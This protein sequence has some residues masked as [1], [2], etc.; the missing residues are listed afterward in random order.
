MDVARKNG[1]HVALTEFTRAL[2]GARLPSHASSVSQ[3]A[4]AGA[5]S[6]VAVAAESLVTQH[7]NVC[8]SG[9][10]A[11]AK[12]AQ[13]AASQRGTGVKPSA[14]QGPSEPQQKSSNMRVPRHAPTSQPF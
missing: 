2:S 3:A 10:V 12:A 8:G 14:R 7:H 5:A 6:A 4:G 13:A 11:A 1:H 9:A